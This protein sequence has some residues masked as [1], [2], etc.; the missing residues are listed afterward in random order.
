LNLVAKVR[1]L[2]AGL[3]GLVASLLHFAKVAASAKMEGS[4]HYHRIFRERNDLHVGIDDIVISNV[5]VDKVLALHRAASYASVA[6]MR[7][8]INAA[9]CTHHRW[10]PQVH[11]EL[12]LYLVKRCRVIIVVGNSLYLVD[13]LKMLFPTGQAVTW[14]EHRV[15]DGHHIIGWTKE[16]LRKSTSQIKQLFGV[17]P[18][19][20][21][22]LLRYLLLT[23]DLGQ[24]LKAEGLLIL[25]CRSSHSST[26]LLHDLSSI[27]G[28]F[29]TTSSA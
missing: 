8:I 3:L 16:T 25:V 2:E 5:T 15:V 13:V 4:I 23:V 21:L 1:H 29:A 24:N 17:C 14:N 20:S 9:I 18:F 27:K 28:A 6:S 22:P 11:G 7:P 19:G 26:R 10:V 12:T